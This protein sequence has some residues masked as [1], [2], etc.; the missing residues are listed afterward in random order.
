MAP[1][2]SAAVAD[3]WAVVWWSPERRE[4]Y[5]HEKPLADA[6]AAAHHG[7]VV[8]LLALAPW[9]GKPCGGISPTTTR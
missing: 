1:I 7:I 8:P 6:Y 2:Q 4:S 9:P 3:R 5:F